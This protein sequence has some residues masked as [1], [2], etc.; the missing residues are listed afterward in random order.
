MLD[1]RERNA[2]MIARVKKGESYAAVAVDYGITRSRVEKICKRESVFS[3]H[4]QPLSYEEKE[5]IERLFWAG[6][7]AAHIAAEIGRGPQ[8][9]VNYLEQVGLRKKDNDGIALDS[10]T[11]KE[12]AILRKLYGKEP[13]VQTA[14]RLKRTKNEVIGRARRLGLNKPHQPRNITIDGVTRT[15]TE[16]SQISGVGR[17]TIFQRLAAG[18]SPSAAVLLAPDRQYRNGAGRP[19]VR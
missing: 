3:R 12:D 18:W 7:R 5:E 8:Q 9:V 15:V 4:N 6:M 11:A 1:Y 17:T 10:W 16:W 2:A 19:G 14:A 13:V